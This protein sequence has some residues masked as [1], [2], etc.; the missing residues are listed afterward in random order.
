MRDYSK[1]IAYQKA[2]NLV[3]EIYKATKKFPKEEIY[4][5]TSQIRR[6]SV[7]VPSNIVE[8]ASRK[9]DKEYLNFL[10]IARGS[11]AEAGY[12]LTLSKKLNLLNESSFEYLWEL[13]EETAR[14]LFGLI[15]HI[16]KEVTGK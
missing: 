10:Y 12:L 16:E 13:R 2:D 5:V 4:G 15:K 8:G 11:L 6:A 9:S 1:I 14:T 7:S 3:I